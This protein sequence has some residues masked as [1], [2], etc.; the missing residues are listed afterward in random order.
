MYQPLQVTVQFTVIPLTAVLGT[1]YTVSGSQVSLDDGENMQMVPITLIR[2]PVP[3]LAR[4]FAVRLL[5]STT[6]GAAIG[7]PAECIVTILETE[8]AHGIFGKH[9]LTIAFW[10]LLL[11]Y[12]LM[13][14][15]L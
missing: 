10:R 8:D 2:S 3:K 6:G 4:S 13:I 1:D 5:N 14:V 11:L 9:K 7:H 12:F 15:R